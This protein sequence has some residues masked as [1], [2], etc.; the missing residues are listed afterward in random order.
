MKPDM[1]TVIPL[2][3]R[4]DPQIF[5]IVEYVRDEAW[6]YILEADNEIADYVVCLH[7]QGVWHIESTRFRRYKSYPN[8]K[9]TSLTSYYLKIDNSSLLD[10]LQKQRT[11]DDPDWELYDKRDYKHWIVESYDFY[12]DIIADKVSFSRLEGEKARRCI[13]VWDKV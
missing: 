7:F 4:K 3:I 11:D 13:T 10:S 2:D 1:A 8:M 9:E 5:V 6:L 12:T